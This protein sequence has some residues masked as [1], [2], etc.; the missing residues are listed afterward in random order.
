MNLKYCIMTAAIDCKENRHAQAVMKEL[1]ITW[2]ISVPQSMYDCWEFWN[3]ENVPDELPEFLTEFLN[4]PTEFIGNG[5]SKEMA[6]EI[7]DYKAGA[8]K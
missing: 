8:Q 2:Q 1:G 4:D 7:R 5:L 6:E 3:C